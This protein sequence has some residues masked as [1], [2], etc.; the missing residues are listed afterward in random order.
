[1]ELHLARPL[2]WQEE[3]GERKTDGKD[4][5]LN[6]EG[7]L[8]P[9]LP[10]RGDGEIWQLLLLGTCFQLWLQNPSFSPFSLL[11]TMC[12][13]LQRSG[14]ERRWAVGGD[15]RFAV[16]APSCPAPLPAAHRCQRCLPWWGRRRM[17]NSVCKWLTSPRA[18]QP[19]ISPDAL[20]VCV[21]V[22]GRDI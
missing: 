13:L 12:P 17:L 16:L 18:L 9:L 4:E 21:C 14:Q 22:Q 19:C 8:V 2:L 5:S 10:V 11:A 1:M 3:T 6:G 20:Q 7:S 15:S